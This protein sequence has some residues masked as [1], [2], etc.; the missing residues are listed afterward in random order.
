MVLK[1]RGKII[2]SAT[3]KK[4]FFVFDT[5]FLLKIMLIKGRGRPIYLFSKNL[6]IRLWYRQLGHILN[7]RVIATFKLTDGIKIIIKKG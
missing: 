2:G 4:N 6:Q 7:A 5:L 1:Q 3:K